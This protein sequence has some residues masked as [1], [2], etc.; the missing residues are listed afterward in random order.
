MTFCTY[1]LALNQDI[2]DRLR[3][4]IEAV[5]VKYNGEVT[6]DAIAEMKYLDMVFKETL[7]RYPIL[8]TQ[9]RKCVKDYKIPNTNLVIPAGVAILIP[10]DAIHNDEK[11]FEN[12]E[13]FDPERFTEENV[14]KQIPYTYLPFSEGPRICIGLRFG[15]MQTKIGL[16]KLLRN[17]KILPSSKTLI[18][19]KYAPNAGFQSPLGGMWL[20]LE[21]I[22]E[23]KS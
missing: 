13:K 16:I 18:P 7:R 23:N 8:N 15:T 1:E 11:Y 2:Q 3:T 9:M 14:K 20:K 17:F 21:N 19:M 22:K 4:E 5:L 10:V 6:Y 12:P